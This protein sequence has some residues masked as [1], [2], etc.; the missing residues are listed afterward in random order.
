MARGLLFLHDVS[1]LFPLLVVMSACGFNP[2]TLEVQPDAQAPTPTP[3]P[4]LTP[5]A[6]QQV[7][8]CHSQL[9]GV[10]LCFDFETPSLDPTIL[11]TSSGHHDAI[12]SD[13]DPMTRLTQQAAMVTESSS[14]TVPAAPALDLLS[15]LSIELWLDAGQQQD[16]TT[17]IQH[18]DD[19]GIDFHHQP[20]C[21]FNDS[22]DLWAPSWSAGWHHVGCTYDGTTLRTYVDG[23]IVA[24]ANVDSYSS[25][26]SKPLNIGLDYTGG[27][28]D[29][30]LYDRALAPQEIQ[31]MA[32]VTSGVAS[33]PD[34]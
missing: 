6:A 23:S 27:L 1:K 7:A 11:D 3:A 8:P 20:G 28:D 22:D 18:D 5:D 10:V 12:D 34:S 30:H 31:V 17:V 33:C 4:P 14:I 16:D 26:H 2:R 19:F 32:G 21:F 15:P 24:C 29:L 13:V 9:P 25:I